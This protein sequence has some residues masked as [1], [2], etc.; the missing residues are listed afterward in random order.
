MHQPTE[1][2]A[3]SVSYPAIFYRWLEEQGYAADEIF[4]SVGFDTD[5]L[6]DPERRISTKQ[7]LTLSRKG[8]DVTGD[9]A[10][11]LRFGSQLPLSAH[12]FLGFALQASENGEDVVRLTCDY[13]GTCFSA[14]QIEFVD[15]PRYGEIVIRS[16][17]EDPGLYRYTIECCVASMMSSQKGLQQLHAIT[18]QQ[19]RV[20]SSDG[21]TTQLHFNYS[22]PDH[23]RTYREV[24]NDCDLR[25]DAAVTKIA[26]DRQRL[27]RRFSFSNQ[28]S[29]ELAVARC[30]AELQAL[31]EDETYAG[32][33]RRLVAKDL[34]QNGSLDQVAAELHVSPRVLS[35]RLHEENTNFQ[36]VLDGVRKQLAIKYLKTTELT[37][38]EIAYRLNYEHPAN[39]ARAFRKW[40]RQS[41]SDYRLKDGADG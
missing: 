19:D 25:F 14:V 33:V 17:V 26:F 39:F 10:M 7:Y 18:R 35:R 8:L 20:N 32:K 38:S 22:A 1:D 11:G 3:A 23:L 27:K 5:W 34:S 9:P 41:P 24:F 4:S 12:S 6:R 40:T 21:L 30:Q 28:V 36:D 37:V 15:T 31:R 16:D 29:R 13:I 2:S